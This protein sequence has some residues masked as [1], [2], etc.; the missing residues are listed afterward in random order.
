MQSAQNCDTP[1]SSSSSHEFAP[2]EHDSSGVDESAETRESNAKNPRVDDDMEISAIEALTNEVDRALDTA[3]KTLHRVPEECPLESEAVNNAAETQHEDVFASTTM[4]ASLRENGTLTSN[5]P[6][7]RRVHRVHEGWRRGICKTTS[8]VAT[9][10]IGPQQRHGDL[11]ITEKSV[12][13][14]ECTDGRTIWE[15]SSGSV[16]SSQTCLTPVCGLIRQSECH[17]Y[18]TWTICC[19][20]ERTRTSTKSLLIEMRFGNQGQ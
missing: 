18:S 11:E 10:Q 6:Q 17:S 14:E 1:S 3:N 12:W 16:S 9:G 13:T 5:R 2:M 7:K 20:P 8:R 19:W 15:R 4:S